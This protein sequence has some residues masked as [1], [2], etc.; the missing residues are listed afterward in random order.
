MGILADISVQLGNMH[1]PIHSVVA[2]EL[3]SQQTSIQVTIGISDIEQLNTIINNIGKI[4]GII[5]VKRAV[6][7]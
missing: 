5:S 4:K 6:L 3:K 1:I 2:R 7:S